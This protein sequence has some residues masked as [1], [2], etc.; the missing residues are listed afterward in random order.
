[1]QVQPS[2]ALPNSGILALFITKYIDHYHQKKS[3][4]KLRRH[5]QQQQLHIL[6]KYPVTVAGILRNTECGKLSRV[7]CRKS[8][9]ERSANYP[10][11]HFRIPQPKNS[12]FPQIAKL[13]F[14]RIVQQMCNRCIAASGVSRSHPSIFFVVHLP[15]NRVP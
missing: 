15:K 9:A 10:S 4:S 1:M 5:H 13:P 6:C 3:P 8:S 14:A 11:S 12:A 7:I 2:H